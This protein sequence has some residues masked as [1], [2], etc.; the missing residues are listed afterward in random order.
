MINIILNRTINKIKC[1]CLDI[2]QEHWLQISLESLIIKKS[3]MSPLYKRALMKDL[4]HFQMIWI[5]NKRGQSLIWNRLQ[6][7]SLKSVSKTRYHFQRMQT[8]FFKIKYRWEKWR[9]HRSASIQLMI[10]NQKTWWALMI[11]PPRL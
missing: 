7:V 2:K 6:T 9:S 10:S 11:I 8:N 1:N 4:K 5:S 3:W